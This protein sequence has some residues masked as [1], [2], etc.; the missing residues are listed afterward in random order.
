ME[1]VLQSM[2][3]RISA[4]VEGFH[5]ETI[6][7]RLGLAVIRE[8]RAP[9]ATSFEPL[10]SIV[11]QGEKQLVVGDRTLTYGPGACFCTTIS[12]HSSGCVV[13][14]TQDEPYV[15]A[16]L[17]LDQ[18][19]IANLLADQ[20]HLPEAGSIESFAARP[21]SPLLLQA[22]DHLIQLLDLPQDINALGAAREREVLYRLLQDAHG[23][24]LRQFAHHQSRL[25]RVRRAIDWIKQHYNMRL[26]T[27]ELADLAAM[28]VPTFHRHFKAATALTPLQ[29]QKAV[30]LEAARRL[31][32]EN[33][34]VAHTAYAVGYESPS[35]FSREYYRF[36]SVRPSQENRLISRVPLIA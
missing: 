1:Q 13:T 33:R 23:P 17:T 18:D 36:Y 6:I 25:V 9:E 7:P 24:M 16:S 22:F 20:E 4:H 29:Y 35:Q 10:V 26:V 8:Q 11:L 2:A 31:L 32:L 3:R 14:A 30:R 15:A 21:A 19:I 27:E 5:R 28:S 34:D 12:L